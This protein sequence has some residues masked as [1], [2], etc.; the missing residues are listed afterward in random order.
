MIDGKPAVPVHFSHIA[1]RRSPAALALRGREYPLELKG[2][3]WLDRQSGEVVKMDAGLLHDMSDVGLR[4]LNIHVEYKRTNLGKSMA[5]IALPTLAVVDVT[6]PRQ[7]WRNTHVFDD[8]K[9]FSTDAEQDPNVKIHA[10]N[11]TAGNDNTAAVVTTETK[12][13]P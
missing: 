10:E 1:G 13:K 6:T 8:Y 4:S 2:T 7:H 5:N 11:A 3:A 12:E 9:S